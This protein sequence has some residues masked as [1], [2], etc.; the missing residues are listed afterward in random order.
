M[1]KL[2]L[3]LT[4]LVASMG[5]A[6]AAPVVSIIGGVNALGS[7]SDS[8]YGIGLEFA[9]PDSPW[10]MNFAHIRGNGVQD[11]SAGLRFYFMNDK[12]IRPYL[13]AGLLVDHNG[14][15]LTTSSIVDSLGV[16]GA[17][18]VDVMLVKGVR[19]G[20]TARVSDR[21]LTRPSILVSLSKSF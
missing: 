16:Y 18:G 20:V 14:L 15:K 8:L 2:L 12:T 10:T 17:A 9:K 7:K 3:G 13:G 11:S 5:V 4:L 19:L 6:S 21:D 1:K